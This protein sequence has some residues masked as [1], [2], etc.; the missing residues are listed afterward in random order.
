MNSGSDDES[1][2]SDDFSCGS[3]YTESS[4][5][6]DEDAADDQDI[7]K[8]ADE[9]EEGSEE[10]ESTIPTKRAR[11]RGGFAQRGV[12]TRG[13]SSSTS[14]QQRQDLN[15]GIH[16]DRAATNDQGKTLTKAEQKKNEERT[17][18]SSLE[19]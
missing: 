10:P 12:R 19:R 7:T 9:S 8:E 4:S 17:R 2:S 15:N 18:T 13:G 14:G 6:S 3:N 16:D 1:F 5:S 11:T